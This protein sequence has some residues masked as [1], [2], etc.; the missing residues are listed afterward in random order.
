MSTPKNSAMI[1]K[2]LLIFVLN[3]L[4]LL[5]FGQNYVPE[6][7]VGQAA[8]IIEDKI[9]YI[10]GYKFNQSQPTSD[11][12]YLDVKELK[13]TWTD[14]VSLGANLTLTSWHTASSNGI[15]LDSIFIL[16]GVHL[17]EANLNYVYKFDIKTNVISVPI[18]QGKTPQPRQGMNSA[19]SIEG[20]IYIFGGHVGSGDNIIFVNSLDILDTINL[21]WSVGS[22]VNSP[23]GRIYYTATFLNDGTIYYIGGKVDRNNFSPMTE[24]YQ[25]DTIGDKWS[26]KTATAEVAETM[27]GPRMGHTAVLLGSSKIIVYGGLY[28]N[29]DIPYG[30]P[31]KETIA[32]LDITTLVWSIPPLEN[33]NNIPKLAFHSAKLVY[34]A[35]MIITFGQKYKWINVPL[36]LPTKDSIKPKSKSEIPSPN[37]SKTSPPQTNSHSKIVIVCVSIGSV[38]AGLTLFVASIF[39][40]KRIKKNKNQSSS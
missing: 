17:D 28:Y 27:P 23:V 10:G 33:F 38:A 34:D 11:V 19:V 18:I 2:I 12:F 21:S 22:L 3:Q 6:P 4:F 14:L 31:S 8:V 9:Y 15:S 7:R 26:L 30:I 35:A 39:A 37:I 40:Y 13:F 32:M 24:I 29:D 16:G 5:G 20:K 25:Y 1:Y 36:N